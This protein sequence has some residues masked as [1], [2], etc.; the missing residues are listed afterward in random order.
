MYH[1]VNLQGQTLIMVEVIHVVQIKL[2]NFFIFAVYV[3]SIA[4]KFNGLFTLH[5][6]TGNWK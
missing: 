3:N 6:G 1:F 5:D 4:R 2:R